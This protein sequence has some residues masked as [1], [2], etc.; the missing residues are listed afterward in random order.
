ML[1]LGSQLA[2][3]QLGKGVKKARD[4]EEKTNQ[5]KNKK[6]L[7]RVVEESGEVCSRP[8]KVEGLCKGPM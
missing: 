6:R 3:G 4:D 1:I 5:K 2:R 8:R 7:G